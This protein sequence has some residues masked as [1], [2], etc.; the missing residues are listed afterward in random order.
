[1][2][3]GAAAHA[4]VPDDDGRHHDEES[5]E[6]L[7]HLIRANANRITR[8]LERV[9][10]DHGLAEDALQE[11]LIVAHAQ[12]PVVSRHRDPVAW[13]RK[14]AWY[15][16]QNALRGRQAEVVGLAGDEPV[17]PADPTDRWEAEHVLR[18]LLRRL[19]LRQRAVLAMD[20]DGCGDDEIAQQLGLALSTV[21]TYRSAARRAFRQVAAESGY[22][23][24]A[25][26]RP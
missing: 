10:D 3:A 21:R 4:L 7:V 16:L 18:Q 9:C 22:D 23:A 11:A 25:R 1:V 17:A 8:F 19:P 26:R 2:T 14:T 5:H 6:A 20:A 12:W 24:A 13:V 15:K